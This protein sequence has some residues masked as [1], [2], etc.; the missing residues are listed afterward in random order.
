MKR[1]G[2]DRQRARLPAGRRA[3]G[4][5]SWFALLTSPVAAQQE[6]EVVEAVQEVLEA[7]DDE[8]QRRLVPAGIETQE[9]LR[10]RVLEDALGTSRRQEA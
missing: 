5:L 4:W 10:A 3:V 6:K 2:R 7:Q 1:L 9:P 8:A